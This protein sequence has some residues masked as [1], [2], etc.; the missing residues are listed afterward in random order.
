MS[1]LFN[2]N[3]KAR[4]KIAISKKTATVPIN[5]NAIPEYQRALSLADNIHFAKYVPPPPQAVNTVPFKWP[6]HE[7]WIT[8]NDYIYN[9]M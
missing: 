7:E 3:A 9:T 2:F 1:T 6:E 8:P 5:F 4:S